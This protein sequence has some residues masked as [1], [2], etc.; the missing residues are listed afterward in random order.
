MKQPEQRDANIRGFEENQKSAQA[1]C[2]NNKRCR[3]FELDALR[4]LALFMMILHHFIFDL[5]YILNLDVFAFQ[6]TNWF[7]YLLRPIFLNVFLIVSGI[8]CTFSRNNFFRGLRLLAAGA[9]LTIGTLLLSSLAPIEFYILFN[10]IHILAVGILIYAAAA[11]PEQRSKKRQAS[12][13]V[14][15]L[16]L[17]GML[18]YVPRLYQAF[19]IPASWLTLPIGLVPDSFVPMSDYL[20]LIPWLGYFLLGAVIGRIAYTGKTSAF[21]AAP[22]RLIRILMPLIWLGRNS[23]LVYLLHQPVLLA[24]LFALRA[25][26]LL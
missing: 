2:V 6:E 7:E 20:P 14:I 17:A 11:W 13:D 21:P 12:T 18:F 4:G 10:I 1:D 8:C 25:A 26:G 16:L 9:V 5:R 22:D 19:V 23:L 24:I 3:A 15:L